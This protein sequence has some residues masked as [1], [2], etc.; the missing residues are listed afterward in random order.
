MFSICI[1]IKNIINNIYL[2]FKKCQIKRKIV[3]ALHLKIISSVYLR[4]KR[5]LNFR[6][7]FPDSEKECSKTDFFVQKLSYHSQVSVCIFGNIYKFRNFNCTN[8]YTRK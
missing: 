6:F 3:I 7:S 1:N 8:T 5:I 4:I 2:Q